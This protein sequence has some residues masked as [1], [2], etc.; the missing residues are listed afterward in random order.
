MHIEVILPVPLSDTYTYSVPEPLQ[1]QIAPGVLVLVEFGKNKQ[2][3]GIVSYIHQI[4][5]P[6]PFEIKPI[7]GIES[8]SPI[9]RRPQLRFWEWIANYYLCKLGEVYKAVLPSGF[10]SESTKIYKEKT[11][12]YIRLTS[13]YS[14]EQEG[15]GAVFDNLKKAPGQ[16]RLLLSYLDYS[17]LLVPNAAK[18]ITRHELLSK[19]QSSDATLN[20]LVKKGIL[21]IYEKSISRLDIENQETV[22][23]NVLN[24][25][26]KAVYAELLFQFRE[27]NV[28]LLHGVTSSGKTEIYIHLINETLKLNKQALFLLPEIALTTQITQRLKA[29]FGNKL[30][31]YHSKINDN[32]RVEIWNNMLSDEGYQVI[33]G[34]RSSVFLP[35]RELGLIIVDEEH[36]TSYK[37]HDP[38]P[39]Y[40]G[41]NTAIVLASMHGAKVVLGS[42]TPS[43]ESFY[44]AQTGKYGYVP[45]NQRYGATALPEISLVDVKELRRKKRMKGLFSPELTTAMKQ[46]LEAGEQ[47][48]LFQNRRGFAPMIQCKS[49]EW[50]PKCSCCDVSLTL[51]KQTNRMVCHYCGNTYPI[52][53][54]CPDCNNED[55][56]PKGFGTEKVEEELSG[57]LPGISIER[58]DTDTTRSQT[59]YQKIIHNFETGHTQVLIG[60]Q[61]VSKGLDFDKVGLV[62]I[63]S[64]DSMMNFP[65]FRSH[66]RAFQLMSQVAGRAGRR[67]TRGLVIIQTSHPDHPIIQAVQQNDYSGMYNT[68]MEERQLF[69]YPPFYRLIEVTVKHKQEPTANAM[70][71][72]LATHLRTSLGSRVLGP[73]KP[74]IGKIQNY[75]LKKILLKIEISASLERLHTILSEAQQ[76]ILSQA[77]Y[78][79]G[80]IQYDV[81]PV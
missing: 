22:E 19:S 73:D 53:Q 27:K 49:C 32:E 68:Q 62:G 25:K 12:T 17:Q 36:E 48:I 20:G 10:R 42:A 77:D 56:T 66:E 3:S 58:L 11:E 59:G 44:N 6:S 14:K 34:V 29:V 35:F 18:E 31:V 13:F 16:E 5:L 24:E 74:A 28:C 2:Y 46:K 55:L 76:S 33:L 21:E 79:Y 43:I 75:F 23:P 60:T 63:L 67:K 9:L 70:S 65:D 15:L 69:K 80:V 81:D 39:R 54:R 37:Q 72:A 78:K 26:Q 45:L 51:H 40:H 52:P 38:A 30:G 57:I 50:I 1:K 64:A 47:V 7:I 61:M 8:Q 4:P 71:Q 41:R